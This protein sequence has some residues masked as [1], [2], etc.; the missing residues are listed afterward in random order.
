MSKYLVIGL[1]STGKTTATEK[2]NCRSWD[3]DNMYNLIGSIYKDYYNS[4]SLNLNF[5]NK[6]FEA[7]HNEIIKEEYDIVFHSII[8][9]KYYKQYEKFID[10]GYK[11]IF[12]YR[13]LNSYID[14][15]NIRSK[16]SENKFVPSVYE[17][18][19]AIASIKKAS[20]HFKAPIY[21]LNSNEYLYENIL[22]KLDISNCSNLQKTNFHAHTHYCKHSSVVIKRMVEKAIKENFK[23]FGFSEHMPFHT[24]FRP[25]FDEY[26]ILVSEFLNVKKKYVNKIKLYFG[27][28]C[29]YYPEILDHLKKLKELKEVDYLIFGNHVGRIT[30]EGF[31]FIHNIGPLT[32]EDVEFHTK[33]AVDGLKTKLFSC[34]AHPDL[35]LKVYGKWDKYAIDYTNQIIEICT[36]LDIPI[37][38]NVKGFKSSYKE[39]F[40]ERNPFHY[41]A[42]PFWDLVS[43]SN[44][45]VIVGYDAHDYSAINNIWTVRINKYID[46]LKIR[47]NIIH[48][49]FEDNNKS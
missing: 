46:Y 20:Q 14:L 6:I 16:N 47:K 32:S 22:S 3:S 49:L 44:V 13:E 31:D 25:N 21:E 29:E 39:N 26:K 41:P 23:E 15:C 37:E 9:E 1:P 43:K 45:K 42:K 33:L 19:C 27:L 35:F 24:K 48:S 18:E 12:V 17:A 30:Q 2:L 7:V 4:Y 34:Y 8:G 38:L 10:A 5:S 40:D 11:I 36:L 28:E